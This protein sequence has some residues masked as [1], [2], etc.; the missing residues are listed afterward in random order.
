MLP[1]TYVVHHVA[2]SCC[3]SPVLY[4]GDNI[5]PVIENTILKD[6]NTKLIDN[7]KY[8]NRHNN[9]RLSLPHLRQNNPNIHTCQSTIYLY[10]GM[11][12]G[13]VLKLQ[14]TRFRFI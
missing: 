9:E 10:K 4:C 3:G 7:N 5:V 11:H 6:N 2:G 8:N 12:S 13:T 14:H 1:T